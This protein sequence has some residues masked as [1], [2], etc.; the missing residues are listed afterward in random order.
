MSRIARFTQADLAR[1]L[2][3]FEA[4][5]VSVAKVDFHPDGGFTI[6]TGTPQAANDK[7]NPLDRVL[8]R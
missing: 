4:A 3:G 2:K 7:G 1:A 5:G 8:G 6:L